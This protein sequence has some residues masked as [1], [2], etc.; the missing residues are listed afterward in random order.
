ML[1]VAASSD[2]HAELVACNRK[3][4]DRGVRT[5]MA[6]AA[7]SALAA[8]LRVLTRD[9]AL[10]R[11]A[12]ER[13]A[14]W[15]IQ[16]TSAVSIASAA[17]VLLEI[18]GSLKLFGGLSRLWSRIEQE[19][20]LLG[21]A[22]SMACAPT[23]FAA[24]LFTRSGLPVRI[25][26]N[27]ALCVSLAQLPVDVLDLSSESNALLHDIGARTIGACLKLPRSGLAR[28]L[29]RELLDKLDRALGHIP[30]PRL[31]FV[32]PANF[33]ATLQLPSP[34][35]EAAALLFAARRVLAELTGFLAATGKGAQRLCFRLAHEGLQDTCINLDLSTAT[36]DL[37]HLTAVLR[38][39]LGRLALPSPAIAITLECKLLL[40]LAAR[41]LTLLPDAREQAETIARLVERLR[42]RLGK[43]TVQGLDTV[44]D[45]RPEYAWRTAEPGARDHG[46]W[47][48]L[49]RPLWILHVPRRLEEIGDL[50]QHE[51]QLTL[52]AGPERIES[53]WWDGND[54]G[55]EYFVAR[56][57][58]QSLLWIF[59]E[60][61]AGG[62]WYLHGYFS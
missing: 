58:A 1:A 36:R 39:R 28:R 6:V 45:Y 32:P 53:G 46:T 38:E 37:E 55:R 20:D 8:D 50:P 16:F 29:D 62:G 22:V 52:L 15:A 49:S 54:V 47:L 31:A 56:S 23:P 51:G 10:E 41:N 9:P 19:L 43:D 14:S 27:D 34:V 11:A 24:Q 3:A 25:Q 13:I 7:A 44:A 30:D 12:L 26:H 17:E 60:L 42:A 35:A 48:P 21:Y 4:H 40:P 2:A 33:T 5:G 59:R 57:P 18:E 61:R